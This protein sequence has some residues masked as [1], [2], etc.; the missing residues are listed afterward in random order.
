MGTSALPQ[1]LTPGQGVQ[2]PTLR[3]TVL[4]AS[5]HHT[6]GSPAWS[7]RCTKRPVKLAPLGVTVPLPAG[8][9]YPPVATATGA[10]QLT[11]SGDSR[12]C[13]PALSS[14]PAVPKYM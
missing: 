4:P 14:P 3:L 11:R 6:L 9:M 7:L 10:A 8:S 5:S 1:A 13:Q 2:L 12:Y